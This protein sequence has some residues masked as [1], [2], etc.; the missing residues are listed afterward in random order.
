MHIN[1]IL[2]PSSEAEL[3]MPETP[4][5][6]SPAGAQ[7]PEF[8]P[9]RLTSLGRLADL[10]QGAGGPAPQDVPFGS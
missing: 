4:D 6:H 7:E 3:P 2:T 1:W 5:T 8:E 9:P 10:T